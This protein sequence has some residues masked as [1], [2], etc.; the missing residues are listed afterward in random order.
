MGLDWLNNGFIHRDL[1]APFI[2]ESGEN[3]VPVLKAKYELLQQQAKIAGADKEGLD[4]IERYTAGVIDSLECY[5]N[6]DLVQSSQA[7]EKLIVELI[8]NDFAVADLDN[9]YAF[10]GLHGTEVQLFRGRLGGVEQDFH[11]VDFCHLPVS[12]RL[13]S[14][15]YRFSI[16]GNPCYYLAN[17][18]YG[19]WIEMGFPPEN[20]FTVSPVLIKGDHTILNLA[21]SVRDFGQLNFLDVEKC[22]CWLKLLIL[23]IA[24]SFRVKTPS[25]YLRPE[26]I[27]SQNIMMA[28]RKHGVDGVAYYSKRVANESFAYCAINLALFIRYDGEGS[29]LAKRMKVDE[30]LCYGLYRQ[31]HQS[32]KHKNYSLRSVCHPYITN[33]GSFDRQ[34]PYRETDFYDF[35]T[36]L[37]AEWRDRGDSMAKDALPWGVEGLKC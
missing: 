23:M 28:C 6:A 16:P 34:S 15:N 11:A 27:I 19:C 4:L 5:F 25:A 9:S 1:Y 33:I 8:D 17:S 22:Q 29:R 14:G 24:T 35:D 12:K 31:L 2:I 37:F 21:V 13:K 20:N 18:S 36:Y 7:I 30:P 10:P 3:Y 26:Y 32:L